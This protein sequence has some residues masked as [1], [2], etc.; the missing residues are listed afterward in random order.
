MSSLNAGRL[1]QWDTISRLVNYVNLDEFIF[2]DVFEKLRGNLRLPAC[3]GNYHLSNQS[4]GFEKLMGFRDGK[5]YLGK[6]QR[7]KGHLYFCT[8][9]LNQ[10][11]NNL[12][13]QAE[14]FIP[15]LYKM[16]LSTAVS[17]KVAYTIGSDNFVELEN[18]SSGAEVVYK[19]EG[20]ASFI[21][22][23]QSFGKEIILNMHDQV[24]IPGIYRVY[25]EEGQPLISL[26]F[27]SNR[28]ESDP[29]CFSS[30]QLADR[31]GD[32]INLVGKTQLANLADYIK[33]KDQ[34]VLLWKY[35][36]ILAL[37]F[38]ALETLIIRFWKV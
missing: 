20:A 5:T 15:M 33:E 17:R 19:V 3:N 32:Q 35:C 27:N 8:A 11:F 31:Y 34:G 24:Q 14:V 1:Q 22:G 7:E 25:L 26:G 6:Y 21:P 13:T 37:I 2:S 29:T 38:L 4:R 12:V 10:S 30:D 28:M 18:A 23:Q 16:A 9:P 36:L